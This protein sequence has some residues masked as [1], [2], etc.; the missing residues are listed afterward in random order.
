MNEDLID[1]PLHDVKI[2]TTILQRYVPT[3]EGI[4]LIIPSGSP[5]RIN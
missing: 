5:V 4:P 2:V 1:L 3:F